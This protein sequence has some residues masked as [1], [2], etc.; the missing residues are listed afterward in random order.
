MKKYWIN[1]AA[2]AA[3]LLLGTTAL[4]DIPNPDSLKRTS[5]KT[6]LT[7]DM[8][9]EPDEKAS[10]AK[11]LIPREIWGQM[12]AQ[13]DGKGA[14]SAG[15]T[16]R[17]FNMTSAQTVVSGIFL[18][19]AFAFGGVWLVR[20]RKGTQQKLSRVA[21]LGVVALLLLSGTAATVAFANAGPPPEA[22][23]LTS[24]VLAPQLQWWGAY[25]QVKVE[26]VDE[27][28]E[29]ILVLPKQKDKSE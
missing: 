20:S 23:T 18:S 7:T 4:A 22:R 21:A 26:I 10:E 17:F 24:K 12:K 29:I 6:K 5:S 1:F 19:M 15:A 25:G 3:L 16:S 27:G 8:R 28:D 11:L 14:Q 9:L 13:L 2:L